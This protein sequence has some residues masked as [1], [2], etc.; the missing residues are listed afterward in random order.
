MDNHCQILQR[1]ITP[2]IRKAELSLL[3]LTRRLVLFYISTKYHKNIPKDLQLT[4]G[5]KINGL[6]LSNIT[7]GDNGKSNHS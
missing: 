1:K 5:H 2:K 7:K 3:Y 6:S 4:S